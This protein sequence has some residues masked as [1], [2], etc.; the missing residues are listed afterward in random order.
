MKT[1]KLC[2]D[3]MFRLLF[4][5]SLLWSGQIIRAQT[6]G[7]Y[8][9]AVNGIDAEKISVYI[10]DLRSGDVILDINGEEP[11]IPASIQKLFTAATVFRT[12]DLDAGYTTDVV[13][14]GK[15]KNGVLNGDVIIK[16]CGDPTIESAHF[17]DFAGFPDSIVASITRNGITHVT[18]DVVVE[19][20]DWL[21]EPV[22][23]GWTDE[24]IIWPYGTGH[25]AFNYADNRFDMT[26]ERSGAYGF[27]PENPAVKAK[28][29]NKKSG[30][31]VWRKRNGTTYNV[32]HRNKTPLNIAL[33]NPDPAQSF[34]ASVKSLMADSGIV[35]DGNAVRK[36]SSE[37]RLIYTHHSP[38]IYQILESMILRSDNQMAEA[39]LRFPFPGKTRTEAVAAEIE[40]WDQLGVNMLDLTIE[41]GSGLSRNNRMT[42]YAMADLLV[43]MCDNDDNF[44]RFI[45]MLPKTGQTGTLKTFLKDTSLNGLLWA[46]T[47]SLN[48]VQCYAGYA[49]DNV[50]VPTHVVVIMVNGFKGERKNVKTVLQDI[51]IEKLL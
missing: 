40:L 19:I 44:V 48:A 43:W 27:S 35:I 30:L 51:L 23:S 13:A 2:T 6:S 46:K 12:S 50:G 42:A 10:E 39:M 7:R 38:T 11:M 33:A 9:T 20:P 31:N 5:L 14:V 37:T 25:H 36:R 34:I 16:A 8:A 21:E 1:H 24:D 32:Y 3:F 18:G 28:K 4:T 41:D 29:A 47:G 26:F 49:V 17:S 22:P 45:N 15:I